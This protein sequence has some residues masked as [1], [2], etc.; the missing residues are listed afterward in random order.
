MIHAAQ[1]H[2]SVLNDLLIEFSSWKGLRVKVF[3]KG[4]DNLFPGGS[5][6]HNNPGYMKEFLNGRRHPYIQHMR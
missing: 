5:E 2:Q 4:K 6:F 1:S 3:T